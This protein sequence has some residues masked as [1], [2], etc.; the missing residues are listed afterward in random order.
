MAAQA[1]FASLRDIDRR[2]LPASLAKL[3]PALDVAML[4]QTGR[5]LVY[6]ALPH[7]VGVRDVGQLPRWA[8]SG[9]DE[10]RQ[11]TLR[12]GALAHSRSLRLVIA[13]EERAQLV[14]IIG[15]ADYRTALRREEPLW[16][17]APREAFVGAQV[18]GT[19]RQLLA[20]TGLGVIAVSSTCAD[21][22]VRLKLRYLF[23]P[24]AWKLRPVEPD[25]DRAGVAELLG[26]D[27]DG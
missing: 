1:L 16:R 25:I 12:I 21:A 7:N 27:A 15:D 23:A 22:V 2:W 10:L 20:A 14:E 26:T 8:D 24:A 6:K 9:A 4:A 13:R 18:D 19:M 3:E 11:L 17:D 5:R